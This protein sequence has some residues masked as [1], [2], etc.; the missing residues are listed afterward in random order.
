M[1]VRFRARPRLRR[2][3]WGAAAAAAVMLAG[4][5]AAGSTPSDAEMITSVAKAYLSHRAARV[6]SAYVPRKTDPLLITSAQSTTEVF[7]QR[8]RSETPA[9]DAERAEFQGTGSEYSHA[10]VNLADAH[11]IVTGDTAQL[12]ISE[13]T[14][15]FLAARLADPDNEEIP[16]A[17]VYRLDHT[18]GFQRLDGRWKI[19]SDVLD[20]PAWAPDPITYAGAV[21]SGP[22][23]PDA[24]SEENPLAD[25]AE[26]STP[27]TPP[28]PRAGEP[29]TTAAGG[30]AG[31]N[32][33]A[34]I[35]YAVKW[36]YGR[37]P[38]YNK[39]GTDCTNFLSQIMRAGGWPNYG[40]GEHPHHWWRIPP[41]DSRTWSIAD[42]FYWFTKTSKR[43]RPYSGE[44]VKPGDAVFADWANG[45]A[46]RRIDHAMFVT[47]VANARDWNKIYVT[48]HTEDRLNI[49]MARVV[50]NTKRSSGSTFGGVYYFMDTR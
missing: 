25:P 40:V 34:A 12:R 44:P 37:N 3:R 14:E 16:E 24:P 11:V 39:Y 1:T 7:A 20:L 4:V 5:P 8:T 17:T 38:Q 19:A 32:R 31:F 30:A 45:R 50:A 46:D 23:E 26:S 36:A 29:M 47:K 27:E 2:A 13:T 49:S 22:A 10:R 42:E 43:M 33:I 48:Y 28:I 41:K 15:L 9:I 21:K 6:T 18:M 35:G